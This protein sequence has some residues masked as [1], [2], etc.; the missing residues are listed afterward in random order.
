MST[1]LAK[2][3]RTNPLLLSVDWNDKDIAK[4]DTL[5]IELIWESDSSTRRELL[6]EFKRPLVTV[7]SVW[8]LDNV[9]FEVAAITQLN[10]SNYVVVRVSGTYLYPSYPM[11]EFLNNFMP[12]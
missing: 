1:K 2:H 7:G 5:R 12:L 6:H 8:T 10:G 11:A 4:F 9:A 3:L